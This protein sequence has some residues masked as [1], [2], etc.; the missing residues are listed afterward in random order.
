MKVST[1]QTSTVQTLS[2]AIQTEQKQEQS[3]AIQVCIKTIEIVDEP[4]D[5]KSEAGE[6][7]ELSSE[8]SDP[9]RKGQGLSINTGDAGGSGQKPSGAKTTKASSKVSILFPV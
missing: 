4:I 6:S 8:M 7:E 2:E 1:T 5:Q 3:Q 9:N